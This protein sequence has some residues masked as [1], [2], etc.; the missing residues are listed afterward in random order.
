MITDESIMQFGKYKGKK[1]K[2]VPASY[3]IWCYEQDWILKDPDLFTYIDTNWNALEQEVEEG[4]N[5]E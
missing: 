3:L 1:M 2:D 4:N 5:D